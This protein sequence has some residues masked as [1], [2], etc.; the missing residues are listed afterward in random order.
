MSK[1]VVLF[2]GKKVVVSN[3]ELCFSIKFNK[4]VKSLNTYSEEA[5][6]V[7]KV[8]I[9]F[10]SCMHTAQRHPAAVNFLYERY[11]KSEVENE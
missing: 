11:L 9:L 4:L 6:N 7:R 2:N 8:A 3:D 5:K 1:E 10:C